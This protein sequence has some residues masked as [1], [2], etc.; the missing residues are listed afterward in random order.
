MEDFLVTA[1]PTLVIELGTGTGGFSLYLA[2]YCAIHDY[3]FH[4]F[5][6]G[7][8]THSHQKP[9]LGALGSILRLGGSVHNRDVFSEETRL[10]IATIV[11][12]NEGSAFIYCDNGDKP[13]EA[14]MYAPL[15]RSGDYLGVHD[16]GTEIHS[17]PE[18]GFER[19]HWDKVAATGSTNRFIQKT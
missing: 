17:L 11:Q 15:L 19:W 6:T 14:E 3:S 8:M 1:W 2:G 18:D 9:N 5:D 4:T 10:Y 12:G 13:K 7:K 16:F